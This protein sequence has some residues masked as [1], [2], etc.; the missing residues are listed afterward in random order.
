MGH[1]LWWLQLIS[2][3]MEHSASE[4]RRVQRRMSAARPPTLHSLIRPTAPAQSDFLHTAAKSMGGRGPV[5]QFASMSSIREVCTPSPSPDCL[6]AKYA[7]STR[8]W[9]SRFGEILFIKKKIKNGGLW[10]EG[11]WL[12]NKWKIQLHGNVTV[13]MTES[14]S[15]GICAGVREGF[16][17]LEDSWDTSQVCRWRPEV[18]LRDESTGWRERRWRGGGGAFSSVSLQME[19]NIKHGG[20][21]NPRTTFHVVGAAGTERLEIHS[22]L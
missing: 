3:H 8:V 20:V 6:A 16:F 4:S 17:V 1:I 18:L 12:W 22:P 14:F 21:L 15:A 5:Y 7:E 13:K 9:H 10:E 19:R 2:I 11:H